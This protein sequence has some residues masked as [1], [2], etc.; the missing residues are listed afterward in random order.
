MDKSSTFGHIQTKVEKYAMSFF[1]R[2]EREELNDLLFQWISEKLRA[3][4]KHIK[5]ILDMISKTRE[6]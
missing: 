1:D 4:N 3:A 6:S 5:T 2:V